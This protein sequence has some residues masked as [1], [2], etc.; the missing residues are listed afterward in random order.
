[1]LEKNEI[2]KLSGKDWR[3]KVYYDFSKDLTSTDSK[4]LMAG[5]NG[6]LYII[7]LEYVTP[8]NEKE[9]IEA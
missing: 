5:S 8:N 1:V 7:A 4:S 9:G 6:C 2:M 3:R